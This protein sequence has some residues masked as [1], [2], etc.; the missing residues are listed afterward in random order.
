MA[1]EALLG[2]KAAFDNRCIPLAVFSE[3]EIAVAGLGEEEAQKAGKQLLVGKFP[4]YASGRALSVDKP[5]GFVKV[6]GDAKTHELLG[7]G[8]VGAEASNLI[9]EASLAIECG[10]LLEDV[11]DT[12]HPH[13]TLSEMIAEACEQALGKCVHL[14]FKKGLQK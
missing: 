4:Y 11:A 9:S 5:V 10:L 3:P 6:I 7:V 2:Q 13:P 12:I 1:A 8:I 14:P